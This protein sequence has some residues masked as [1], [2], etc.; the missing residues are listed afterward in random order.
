LAQHHPF[1]KQKQA[2]NSPQ[3]LTT[4]VLKADARRPLTPADFN[5]GFWGYVWEHAASQMMR[6]YQVVS[7][8]S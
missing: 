6:P 2:Q 5:R 7:R 1:A 4:V 3:S 8:K